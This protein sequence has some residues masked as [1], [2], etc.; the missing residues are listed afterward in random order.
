MDG[1]DSHMPALHT[2]GYGG[3]PGKAQTVPRAALYAAVVVMEATGAT[4]VW[5]LS[6][7]SYFTKG[8]ADESSCE[9]S[10]NYDLWERYWRA[11]VQKNSNVRVS[12]V[13]AHG[14]VDDIREGRIDFENYA[15]NMYADR[16]A[17]KGAEMVQLPYAITSAVQA[18]DEM[19]YKVRERLVAMICAAPT[20]I[21]H[22]KDV[23]LAK[24]AKEAK[25]NASQEE[26]ELFSEIPPAVLELFHSGEL[27]QPVL[28]P[29]RLGGD[30]SQ[31][32]HESHHL[33]HHRGF[34]WCWVCGKY[35]SSRGRGLLTDCPGGANATGKEVLK[36]VRAGLTP[37]S[38]LSWPV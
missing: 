8:A 23:V 20:R 14:N 15:G 6:D 28:E 21:E 12:K 25:R 2:G 16:F 26:Q 19:G 31:A 1:S 22:E 24:Q 35:A 9:G 11:H 33:C 38:S 34:T 36:R 17:V 32:L 27:G 29:L 3:L 30:K 37:H 13:K 18:M 5:L 10:D 7:C 4:P